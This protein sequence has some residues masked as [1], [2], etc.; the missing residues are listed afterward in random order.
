MTMQAVDEENRNLME[1]EKELLRWHQCLGHMAYARIR[2]LMHFGALSFT[3]SKC[4]LHTKTAQSRACPLCTVCQF[5]KQTHHTVPHPQCTTAWVTSEHGVI[6]DR[7]CLPGQCISVDHFVCSTR[8]CRFNTQGA[9]SDENGMYAGGCVFYDHASHY[10]DV[11]FQAHLN[12]HETLQSNEEFEERCHDFGVVIGSYHSNNGSSFMSSDYTHHLQD[13][14]QITSFASVGA[15]HTNGA[16]KCTIHTITN[17]AH[18]MMLHQGI[19]WPEVADPQLW[20]MAV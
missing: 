6:T 10:I 8:G 2:A 4:N 17:M 14:K 20:P 16:A 15:H 1:S 18:T 11:H 12:T 7:D 5:C 3:Q 19:C 13:F 9:S